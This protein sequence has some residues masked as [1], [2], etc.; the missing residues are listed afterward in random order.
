MNDG[1]LRRQ[2]I[3]GRMEQGYQPQAGGG[4]CG[5]LGF[6]LALVAVVTVF[7]FIAGLGIDLAH[8]FH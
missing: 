7:S 8:L 4:W 6:L 3:A 2:Y 1:E 5:C